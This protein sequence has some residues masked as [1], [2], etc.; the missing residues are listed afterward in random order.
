MGKNFLRGESVKINFFYQFMYQFVVLVIPLIVSPY[1]TRTLRSESIGVYT[2]TNSIAYYFVMVAMLGISMYGQRVIVERKNDTILTRKT[3]WSLFSLHSAISLVVFVLYLLYATFFC[4][5]NK[6]VAYA[7]SLYVLSACFDITWFYQGIEKFKT[8]AIRNGLLKIIEC[9]AIFALVK[10]P[11]DILKYTLIM[12]ISMCLGQAILLPQTVIQLPVIRFSKREVLE[13]IKP[14]VVLFLAAVAASLYTVFDKTL[15]GILST[16][17]DVAFYEYS[18]KIIAIPRTFIMVISVVL[19]PRACKIVAENNRDAMNRNCSI[20]LL[21]NFFIGFAAIFGLCAVGD[22]FV[23]IYYGE[24]FFRCGKIIMAMSPLILIIGIGEIVR[25]QYI[26][27]LKK[28]NAMVRILFINA[29]VNLILS[30]LLIP[31]IGVYGAVVGTVVA[32]IVGFIMEIYICRK[33]VPIK[34]I[35]NDGFPFLLFGAI[36]FIGVRVIAQYVP[37]SM[38][39]LIIEIIIGAVIYVSLSLSYCYFIRKDYKKLLLKVCGT[40]KK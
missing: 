6:A 33:F 37:Q 13:H 15:L 14:M 28:D 3:F 32:E 11:D 17:A 7:Q 23:R 16:K 8:V 4:R 22:L 1:L 19:F 29:A 24:E 20:S 34:M 27:P 39:G 5:E 36:M 18:N 10:S 40:H 21:V 31:N 30:S 35:I 25:S 38:V 26:Y 9:I 2:Y 12:T